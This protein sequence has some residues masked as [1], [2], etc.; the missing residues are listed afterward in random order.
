[1]SNKVFDVLKWIAIIFLPAI[2]FFYSTIAGIWGLPYGD[3]ISKTIFAL[4]TLL[5]ALL[6]ISTINYNS[7]KAMNEE[8]SNG[9]GDDE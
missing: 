9:I 6:G 8:L 4:E 3:E 2:S 7:K 5:G 1:M